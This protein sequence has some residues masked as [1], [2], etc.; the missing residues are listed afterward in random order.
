MDDICRGTAAALEGGCRWVQLRM[1]DADDSSVVEAASRLGALCRAAGATFILDDRVEL[2]ER[3]GAHGVHL[4]KSDMPVDKAIA[5]LG[6]GYIVGATANTFDDIRAAAA[7]G[8]H[9]IGLGPLRFTTTKKNLSPVLGYR[10]YTDICA[11]CRRAG[12]TLPVVAIGG[13]TDADIEP[14]ALAGVNGVAVSGSIARDHDPA[15]AT[16]VFINEIRKHII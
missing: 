7:L 16:A 1:K 8:A 12:I 6:P 3:T 9:Y 14:L 5:A 4:G 11:S 15:Q 2:V 10:G 13:I